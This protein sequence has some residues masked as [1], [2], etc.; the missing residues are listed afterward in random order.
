[1]PGNEQLLG[2]RIISSE[3]GIRGD[4]VRATARRTGAGFI[5]LDPYFKDMA[6]KSGD[7]IEFGTLEAPR[8]FVTTVASANVLI[9]RSS[10]TTEAAALIV[11]INSTRRRSSPTSLEVRAREI[12]ENRLN[13]WFMRTRGEM[14]D[15]Y[16]RELELILD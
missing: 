14:R 3:A 5:Q 13:D 15:R 6:V 2:I 7:T 11:G 4:F 10:T 8:D 9:Q 16:Q 12:L 1:M